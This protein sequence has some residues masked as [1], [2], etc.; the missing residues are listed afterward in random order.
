[1]TAV[2]TPHGT[3]GTLPIGEFR[4]E[5]GGRLPHAELRYRVFGD[6]TLAR[7][8]GAILVFHALTGS[9]D[10]DSWWEPL[11]GPGRALDTRRHPVI[12]ANLLGSCYGSTGPAPVTDGSFPVLTT[13]DLARAHI[14]LLQQ[15]GVEHLALVTGGSLGGM[16]A[17]QWGLVTP[18]PVGRL[19]VFAAPGRTTP[20][21][22]AWNAAQRMAIE[23]DPAWAG[24]RYAPGQG[25][26]AG[27]AA[28]RAIAMITYRSQVEF[29]ERFGRLQTRVPG[30]FD[31]EHYLRRHGEKLVARFDA[32]TYVQLM[33]AMDLHDVGE[34]APAGRTTARRVGEVIGV[35]IDTDILYFPSEVQEWVIG[36][37]AGGARARYEEITT[38]YGHDAFLIEFDQVER[39]L[40]A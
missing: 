9:A 2:T 18:V 25:P 32:R 20:Q 28:A 40:R 21:A 34:Y 37:A 29:G 4:P 16:V 39:I 23:A 26:T 12:A 10:I 35:G 6:L 30:R 19:V 17:L 31:I 5:R 13:A 1:M 14:P 3:S 27:L 22:I 38:P 24:G 36:Y 7:E 11:I 15:L 8:H 33:H